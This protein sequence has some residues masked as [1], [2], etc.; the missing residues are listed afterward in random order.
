MNLSDPYHWQGL[1]L[2]YPPPERPITGQHDELLLETGMG[3][4]GY[5]N[6]N[7]FNLLWARALLSITDISAH[8][9]CMDINH[10]EDEL[11]EGDEKM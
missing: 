7:H 2:K 9:A 5:G 3:S 8:S 1:A 11:D 10:S 4:P 6:A